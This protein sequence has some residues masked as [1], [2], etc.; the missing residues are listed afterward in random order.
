MRKRAIIVTIIIIIG[1]LIASYP[2]VASFLSNR[3]QRSLI[4]AYESNVNELPPAIIEDEL[5]RA[6]AYNDALSGLSAV[7]DPFVAGSGIAYPTDY[8]TILNVNGDGIM[9]SL[10]IP[11]LALSIPIYHGASDEVLEKGV[12]H[13]PETALPVG[14]IGTGCI[15]AAHRGRPGKELFTNVDKLIIG[16]I[17]VIHVLGETIAYEIED[18]FVVEPE[19]LSQLYPIPGKDICTLMTCT[20]LNINSHRLLIRGVRTELDNYLKATA[21]GERRGLSDFEKQ[22]LAAAITSTIV[23]LVVVF[24]AWKRR[25]RKIPPQGMIMDD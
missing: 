25:N 3:V 20:P 17:F 11:A 2:F 5:A 22:M 13:I 1:V 21:E 14:G 19:E 6:R 7:E 9:G 8:E 10:E 15:L 23:M 16:D 18:I 24:V 12:G 4:E